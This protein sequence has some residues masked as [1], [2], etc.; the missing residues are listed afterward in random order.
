MS[1]ASV[2][3]FRAVK[4]AQP[5]GEFY[6]IAIP[7]R[8][9]SQVVFLD[10]TRIASVDRESFL[11]KL[12]GNQREAS[13][14]RAKKIA[15][16]INTVESAFPNSIILAGNY[17]DSGSFQEDPAHRWRVE[18]DE[19]GD[20]LIIPSM[21]RM[22]SV[23]DGQH[24]LLGFDS[25]KEERRDMELLCSVYMDLPQAYQAY[26]FATINMNQRKVDKSL[27]YEQFGYNLDEEKPE[28][29]APDKLA[30]FLTRRLNLNPESHLYQHIKIAPLE[31]DLIFPQSEERTWI[32]ST[33]CIVEGILS[34]ISS[35][36][37]DD[38][39]KLHAKN[40]SDR[41]R[42]DLPQDSS[43]LRELYVR[44]EDERLAEII[45][46]F[47]RL[48]KEHLWDSASSSSFIRKTIG[49]QALFDV[50]RFVAQKTLIENLEPELGRVLKAASAID[51]SDQLFQ[52]SGKGRVR[53]KNV[54]LFAAELITD[55]DLPPADRAN[56][57]PV[58]S[59]FQNDR[60]ED[61]S[62]STPSA[63][64]Q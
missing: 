46:S 40:V 47:L 15:E 5:L 2:L 28:G 36:P 3:R 51:F 61:G 6:A 62:G 41:H 55:G 1:D 48:A 30:V 37:R 63:K 54:I 14:S 59:A 49:V 52:A 39:D 58:L 21:Q 26:L 42:K 25:C 34:L 50:F 27:A 10:P 35:R 44:C 33:A 16:Y 19:C 45:L 24:R 53:V 17:I 64:G 12:L 22:A 20:Y 56:Y 8:I 60:N 57:Q 11:Y 18:T 13:S 43:P 32:V 29:W 9:L 23:I 38:R 31:A 7:A 4:V